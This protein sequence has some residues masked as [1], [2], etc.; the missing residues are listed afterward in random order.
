MDP[1]RSEHTRAALSQ[2]RAGGHLAPLED[3]DIPCNLFDAYAISFAQMKSIAAWKIGG[4]NPWSR[5][6]F[7][8][9]DSFIGPLHPDELFLETSSVPVSHLNAPMAEPEIMLELTSSD[10]AGR[11]MEFSRM[12][13][14]FEIP[15]SVLPEVLKSSLNGQIADRAGAGALWIAGITTFDRTVLQQEFS[16]RT[17]RNGMEISPGSSTN[18]PD[19]PLGAA[20]EFLR[21]AADIGAPLLPGQWVATGGLSPAVAVA[22]GDSMRVSALEWDVTLTLS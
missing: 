13:I 17:W 10:S 22:A 12:A 16:S 7:N 18:L 3:S 1:T 19:G 8:N 15:A 2:A 14:G 20:E 11:N 21:I 4:A 6:V 5:R 9:K